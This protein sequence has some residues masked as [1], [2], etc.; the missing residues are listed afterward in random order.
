MMPLYLQKTLRSTLLLLVLGPA[1]LLLSSCGGSGG[2]GDGDLNDPVLN[3]TWVYASAGNYTGSVC[4]LDTNGIPEERDTLKF[5]GKTYTNKFEECQIASGNTG[6]FVPYGEITVSYKTGGVY[7]T[8]NGYQLKEVDLTATLPS[9]ERIANYAGYNITG[10]ELR[11]TE[12]DL[13][14][15]G[16]TPGAREKVLA[17]EIFIK[18]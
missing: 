15:D 8:A 3:G 11:S 18:Q 9:G 13:Q 1:V 17:P 5:D 2:D 14:N 7:I 4:G 12:S 10:N 6:T 16:A